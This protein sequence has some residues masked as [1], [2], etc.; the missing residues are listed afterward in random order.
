MSSEFNHL[1]S[2]RARQVKASELRELMK[3][4]E[5]PGMISFAGG[6]PDPAL[7]P[8]ELF[9]AEYARTLQEASG[10]KSLQYAATEGYAPLREWIAAH[11][12]AQGINCTADH[13]LITSGSQQA[14][15][16]IGK[17][18]LDKGDTVG[19]TRPT[20]LG[21]LQ[22]FSS[23][24][25]EFATLNFASPSPRKIKLSYVVPDFANPTG[26]TMSVSDR[27]SL[28]AR[29]R[30]DR[31]LLVEDAAY[32]LLRYEGNSPPALA[33]LD[34]AETGSID[35]TRT[36]YCGTFS[37]TLSPGLRIGWICGPRPLVRRLTLLK[38]GSDLHTSTINQI[39]ALRVANGCFDDQLAKLRKVYR[40]RR[41]AMLNALDRYAPSGASWTRPDGGL[42]IWVE[43]PAEV[44]TAALFTA[45]VDAGVAFVPGAAFYSTEPRQNTMRLSF[46]LNSEK[47]LEEG[48]GRLCELIGCQLRQGERHAS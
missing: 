48:I 37:K 19:V 1:L 41:D 7:F 47:K 3:L 23:Y 8:R 45:A 16:L 40:A 36:L 18:V 11:L 20:Y 35:D 9:A 17:L 13:I 14:L 33:A 38:Q 21:A 29:T 44:D 24:Q 15:D 2:E 32:S 39:V 43:L 34:Q 28:L 30:E 10:G 46:S 22:A 5:R 4:I 12:S 27:K 42:F 31:G 6:I 26:E 25:P